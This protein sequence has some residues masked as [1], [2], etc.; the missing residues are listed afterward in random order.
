M[1][2]ITDSTS[3]EAPK[4]PDTDNVYAIFK[5]VATTEQTESL[6]KKY[7]AG[8]F[9]YGHAKQELFDLLITKYAKE[10]EAF[11]FYMNNLPELEKKLKHS[12][13]KAAIIAQGVLNKVRTKLGFA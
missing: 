2:I 13:E 7:L 1:S 11:N 4:N 3:M 10:R 6:R 5:L 9:G 12:E 8:N